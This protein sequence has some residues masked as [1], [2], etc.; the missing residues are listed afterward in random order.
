M[1]PRDVEG[2]GKTGHRDLR[3]AS[4][5]LRDLSLRSFLMAKAAESLVNLME[6]PSPRRLKRF[7][8]DYRRAVG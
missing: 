1:A 2:L 8:R 3:E 4:K 6:D 7:L 5:T